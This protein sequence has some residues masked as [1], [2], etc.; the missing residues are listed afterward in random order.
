MVFTRRRVAVEYQGIQHSQPVEFFGGLAAFE[1]QQQRDLDKR[2][3]CETYGMD[4]VEVFPDYVLPDVV[5]QIR[6]LIEA[7]AEKHTQ[8]VA[9]PGNRPASLLETV[10]LTADPA[11]GQMS[12]GKVP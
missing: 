11:H 1:N 6:T 12:A 3:L 4:L 10:D 9:G 7:H 5:Q 2:A 8:V